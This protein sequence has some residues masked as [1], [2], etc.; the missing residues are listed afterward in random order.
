MKIAVVTGTSTGIGLTTSLHLARNGYQVFAGMRNL[1]KADALQTAAEAEN[2]PVT[3]V[4]LDVCDT[5]S[6]KQA[7]AEIEKTGPV[8][9][10][11]NNA[12]IGGAAPLEL[13]PEAEH[14]QM[15]ET[16][17]FG[18]V[19]CIQAVLPSMRER[20]TGSIVNITSAVGLQATPN[21]I[22]YS[23][24]KWALE[25][26]GE[27]LA[28]EVYRFGVRVVN[29][30]PGVIMTSIFE[31]SAEQ[32]RYDKTSPYQPIMRRN[33]KV[34]SAG[35]KRAVSPDLV[36]ETILESI[37]TDDYKLRWPVGPDAEGFMAARTT[38]PSEDWIAMGADLTDDE[39]NEKF[40]S[41][42]GIDI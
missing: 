5:D 3:V 38:V 15:F 4:Q 35:F 10:L 40:K 18:V 36:A 11:I 39:Y 32:T 7:F 2:L 31:N 6:V 37:T 41:M 33:G 8:D 24:S 14:K 22:A 9:V 29:V 19:R 13:V 27:A 12:G 21:Q 28:H 42:F 34:F 30:E 17:Y 1:A 25:C 20:Q 23:A 26:L 16:N